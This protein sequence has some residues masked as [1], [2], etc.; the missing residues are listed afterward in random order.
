MALLETGDVEAADVEIAAFAQVAAR[1]RQPLYGWYVPLWRGMRALMQGRLDEAARQCALA[2]QLG[3]QAHSD[4]ARMLTFTQWW[5][6][7]RCEGRFAEAATAMAALLEPDTDGPGPTAAGWPYHAVVELQLGRPDRARAALEQWAAGRPRAP[8]AAT[9][10]GCRSRPSWR[11]LPCWWGADR[12]RSC[13]TT[14]SC[15]FAHRFC[16]EGIGAAVTG[17]VVVVPRPARPLPRRPRRR[18]RA[19][20]GRRTRRTAGSGWSATLPRWRHAGDRR[21]RSRPG[22]PSRRAAMVWEGAT[23]AVT[24]DGT[25]RHLRDSK[26]VA[27]PRRPARARRARRCTASSWWAAPTSAATPGRRSTSGP[28][29]QYEQRI[30]E[31]QDDIDEARARHD[32]ARAERAEAELDA[33]VQ[34]LVAGLRP[35]RAGPLHRLGRRAGPLRRRLAD[36]RRAA[37]GRRGAPRR[38]AA[39]CSNA[40]RTGTWCCYRPEIAR[41]GLAR[42]AR[43]QGRRA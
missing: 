22:Q 4:N 19:R 1:L 2:E 38:S 27:R 12:R 15:P 32:P 3:A 39:T 10:S 24:W 14:S 7:R 43:A 9:P 18:R 11:R 36:P 42:S 41:R 31:L 29:A 5:V 13:S 28:G 37:A 20:T 26:G 8:G 40:V 16:V 30:R 33:L 23:W 17:S 6:R 34:Q 35:V 25:T 21:R